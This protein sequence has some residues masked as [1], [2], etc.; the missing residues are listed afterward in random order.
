MSEMLY[1]E[2][3][4]DYQNEVELGEIVKHYA[5]DDNMLDHISGP[6][7]TSHYDD[8]TETNMEFGVTGCV[9]ST[10]NA[11]LDADILTD[12]RWELESK[13]GVKTGEPRS[14]FEDP[15]ANW[16]RRYTELNS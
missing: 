2:I 4:T 10:G 12:I 15:C 9:P 3:P 14:W 13:L 8:D 7:T 16:Y 1:F 6:C 5:S 11:E